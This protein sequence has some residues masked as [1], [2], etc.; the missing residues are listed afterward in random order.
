VPEPIISPDGHYHWNGTAWM[1]VAGAFPSQPWVRAGVLVAT[2]WTRPLRYAI[3]GWGAVQAI[4][5]VTLPFW[6]ITT[7]TRWADAMNL[8][9]SQLHPDQPPPPAPDAMSNT[10]ATGMFYLGIGILL[11]IG[12]TA[13]VG[14]LKRWTWA[15]YTI[16]VLLGLEVIWLAF[17]LLSGLAISAL[18]T[19]VFGVSAGPPAWMMWAQL[20]FGIPSAALLAFMLV[21][22]FRRGPWAMTKLAGS[23]TGLSS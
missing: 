23:Q 8:R 6:Y 17:G 19:T 11:A 13:I 22:L 3:A 12:V 7:M 21:A 1:P 18:T 20:A 15:Y 9:E 16:L 4:W 14:A 2:S 10:I 5:V